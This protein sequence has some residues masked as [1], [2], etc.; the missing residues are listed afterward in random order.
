[1]SHWY[2]SSRGIAR[3]GMAA[4]ADGTYHG[5][6]LQRVVDQIREVMEIVLRPGSKP[7]RHPAPPRRPQAGLRLALLSLATVI[8]LLGAVIAG[9]FCY[10]SIGHGSAHGGSAGAETGAVAHRDPGAS[11]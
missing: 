2:R 6:I 11:T 9:V 1:M 5:V 4:S 7:A 3:Q 8:L 10:E